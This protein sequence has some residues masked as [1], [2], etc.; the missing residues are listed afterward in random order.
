MV[1]SEKKNKK[2][3]FLGGACPRTPIA[4]RMASPCAAC[5]FA[6]CKFPNLKSEKKFLPP[7]PRLSNPGNAPCISSTLLT[8]L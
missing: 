2:S 6:T 1:I 4:E 7:P 3:D 5:S 8:D